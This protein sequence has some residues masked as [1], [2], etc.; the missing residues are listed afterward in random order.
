MGQRHVLV[1]LLLAEEDAVAGANTRGWAVVQAAVR[2]LKAI[3]ACAFAGSNA[4]ST[5]RAI[6]LADRL[7]ANGAFPARKACAAVLAVAASVGALKRALA[8]AAVSTSVARCTLACPRRNAVTVEAAVCEAI[9]GGARGPGPSVGAGAVAW[10]QAATVAA[11]IV[12]ANGLVALKARVAGFAFADMWLA[13]FA[14]DTATARVELAAF[15]FETVVADTAAVDAGSLA[16]AV[17]RTGRV[18]AVLS[19]VCSVAHALPIGVAV[20]AWL[21]TGRGAQL[22]VA[23]RAGPAFGAFAQPWSDA[24]AKRPTVAARSLAF[25]ADPAWG[26]RALACKHACAVPV[27]I[28]GAN[29]GGAGL[30]CPAWVAG[31][32]VG[33]DALPVAAVATQHGAALGPSV[34]SVTFAHTGGD[35]GS[36]VAAVSFAKGLTA[37]F[38]GPSVQT[39]A[40]LVDAFAMEIAVIQAHLLGTVVASPSGIAFAL[41]GDAL[42]MLRAFV[43]AGEAGALGARKSGQTLACA[44]L[45]NPGCAVA[46]LCAVALH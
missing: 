12:L 2:T 18:H 10:G 1:V 36:V 39:L 3:G 32:K 43:G 34:P 45:A 33:S 31:A 24:L 20:P 6:I 11:A 23:G 37:G 46:A 5:L 8:D 35:A 15:P 28:V 38:A 7:V 19:A 27:A 41:P 13:A 42:A 44:L 40:F 30:A 22:C 26:A 9:R 21:D 17:R 14:T 25:A 16:M 29:G 4:L